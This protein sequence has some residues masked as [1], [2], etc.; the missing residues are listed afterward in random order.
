M[1]T[2]NI[3]KSDQDNRTGYNLLGPPSEYH[4]TVL[5]IIVLIQVIGGLLGNS[6]SICV[7]NRK[8]F[9]ESST[10][11]YIIVL[12]I[13]DTLSLVIG[14]LNYA[15]LP[16]KL[17]GGYVLED[18][19]VFPCLA[20]KYLTYVFPHVSSWCLCAVTVERLLAVSLP[21]R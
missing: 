18:Q 1:N 9:K 12:A 3:S 14:P 19:G 2:F 20:M 13:F 15:V 21:H 10:A 4:V 8:E 17:F 5:A 16:S 6:L 11:V 7:M